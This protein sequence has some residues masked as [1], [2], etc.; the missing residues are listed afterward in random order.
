MSEAEQA[1]VDH[2]DNH[3]DVITSCGAAVRVAGKSVLLS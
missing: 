2:E 1:T 3:D